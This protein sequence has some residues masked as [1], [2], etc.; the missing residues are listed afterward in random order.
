MGDQFFCDFTPHYK[1]ICG[2]TSH[3][4][5]ISDAVAEFIDNAIQATSANQGINPRI[6]IE[7]HISQIGSGRNASE[8]GYLVIHDNGEYCWM[9]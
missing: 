3:F 7:C 2:K 1:T 4:S 6:S 8:V 9:S 5:R